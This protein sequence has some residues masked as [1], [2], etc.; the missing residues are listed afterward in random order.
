[1]DLR[2]AAMA[3]YIAVEAVCVVCAA[4]R[5]RMLVGGHCLASGSGRL[6]RPAAIAGLV[7]K[8]SVAVSM[9]VQMGCERLVYIYSST[10]HLDLIIAYVHALLAC[11]QF[12]FQ[13]RM[14]ALFV[15][16]YYLFVL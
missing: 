16:L 12:L 7:G 8:Y 2:N 13:A 1:M 11:I 15:S 3:V 6:P 4:E 5:V 10:G 9:P 14:D